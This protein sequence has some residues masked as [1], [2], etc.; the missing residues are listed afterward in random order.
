MVDPQTASRPSGS[1]T[2]YS[3]SSSIGS[4]PSVRAI[5]STIAM[6]GRM[7]SEGLT[8]VEGRFWFMNGDVGS[9]S[10]EYTP[11]FHRR[12]VREN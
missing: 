10:K 11:I 3:G 2:S 8:V 12:A 4:T 9:A 6:L 5:R 1:I 7:S